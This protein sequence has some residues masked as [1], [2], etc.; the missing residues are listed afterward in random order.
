ML[1]LNATE[2][3]ALLALM[4]GRHTEDQMRVMQGVY[5]RLGGRDR[6]R[7]EIAMKERMAGLVRS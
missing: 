1:T 3:K 6:I 4:E 7:N 2:E 5:Q